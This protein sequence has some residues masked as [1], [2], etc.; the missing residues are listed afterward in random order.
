MAL[1][2][3]PECGSMISDK[4]PD[5]IHCGFPLQ[6]YLEQ[7]DSYEIVI[8][9]YE[10]IFSRRKATEYQRDIFGGDLAVHKYSLSHLPAIFID[11]I[12]KKV[13]LDLYEKLDRAGCIVSIYKSRKPIN[14]HYMNNANLLLNGA[15]F[16]PRC[17]STTVSTGKR[18]FSF[19]TGFI[20]SNTTVN[21]CAK[22][23]YSWKP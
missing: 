6:D 23:G 22:C 7:K 8:E 21:R 20:G 4:A 18:G 11:G 2:E 5:C 15:I 19:V 16:C 3:C 9:E 1:I 10:G 17:H 14:T 13:A 12:S